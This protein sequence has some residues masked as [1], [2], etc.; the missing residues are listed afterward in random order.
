MGKAVFLTGKPGIGKTTVL[1]RVVLALKEKGY[2]VGGM[3]TSEVREKG[4]RIGFE[5]T[6]LLTGQ[7]GFL[8]K[9]HGEGP[10]LG[11][12]RVNLKDL[13]DVGVN[14]VKLA[15]EKSDIVVV[16]EV[17]PMELFSEEFKRVVDEAL[18]SDKP[19]IGVIHYRAKDPLIEK[20]KKSKN[21]TVLE[22]TIENRDNLPKTVVEILL[23]RF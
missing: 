1:K 13:V 21:V 6:D 12:Y 10:R 17:G 3:I 15:L 16:D 8:A 2:N 9:L 23:K 5:I 22:V 4:E 20:V 7:K 19:L 11:K 14:A 18:K